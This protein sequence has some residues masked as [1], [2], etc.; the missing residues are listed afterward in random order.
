MLCSQ[1]DLIGLRKGPS[2]AHFPSLF[3]FNFCIVYFV[4]H[5][6]I[7]RL[8]LDFFLVNL[9]LLYNIHTKCTKITS[10]QLND[11]LQG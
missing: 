11:F 6:D 2:L 4:L 5:I 1:A 10:A 8:I 7:R 3:F 9:L